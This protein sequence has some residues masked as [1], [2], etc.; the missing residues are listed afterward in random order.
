MRR[1]C[2]DYEVAVFMMVP[3]DVFHTTTPFEKVWRV[4]NRC[5]RTG[6][7]I[8]IDGLIEAIGIIGLQRLFW[9]ETWLQPASGWD[10]WSPEILRKQCSA[11]DI[12]FNPYCTCAVQMVHV[13]ALALAHHFQDA[14]KKMRNALLQHP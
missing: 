7:S 11:V 12:L 5:I 3:T 14:H 10:S 1:V 4:W 13:P 9:I 6:L 8:G 2:E